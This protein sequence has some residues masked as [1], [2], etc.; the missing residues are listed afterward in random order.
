M[1]VKNSTNLNYTDMNTEKTTFESG[2]TTH[3]TNDLVLFADNTRELAAIRDSIY[4]NAHKENR[5]PTKEDFLLLLKQSMAAYFLEFPTSHK[6]ISNM[7]KEEMS[8]F[9]NLY[10]QDY[11]N[12]K[13]ENI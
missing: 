1:V 9:C 5:E 13:R 12:W 6:H 3:A 2:A 11:E 4:S 8:E 10:K 7:T